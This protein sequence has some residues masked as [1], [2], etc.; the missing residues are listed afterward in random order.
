MLMPLNER[1]TVEAGFVVIHVFVDEEVLRVR[2]AIAKPICDLLDS[3]TQRCRNAPQMRRKMI[4]TLR[5][6]RWSAPGRRW[7]CSVRPSQKS[8]PSQ[9]SSH[10]CSSTCGQHEATS[11]Q[12]S[13]E[14]CSPWWHS[15]DL[16]GRTAV[17]QD[18][19]APPLLAY[20]LPNAQHMASTRPMA[21]RAL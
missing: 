1:V 5:S 19:V 18:L 14:P 20:Q 3:R 4:R 8:Q 2:V 11:K 13:A 6:S 9:K 15:G 16:S 10:P 12:D 7:E 17:Q 21:D